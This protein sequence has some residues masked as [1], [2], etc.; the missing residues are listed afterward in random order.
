MG[1]IGFGYGSEWHLLRWLGYHRGQLTRHVTA[2]TGGEAVEWLDFGFS[3]A[4]APGKPDQELT[5][6]DFI[7]DAQVQARWRAFWPQS[8]SAQNWDAVGVIHYQD[9]KEWLLVEA[10]AHVG[11]LESEC[12]ARSAASLQKIK[13]ALGR[14]SRA[15]CT[16]PPPVENWLR[17]YYQYANRLAALYFLMKE[18][19]PSVPARLLTIYFCGEQRENLICP[20]SEAEWQPA[21]EQVKARLGLAVECELMQRVQAL[22]L[23]VNPGAVSRG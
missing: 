20:Q 13:T 14:A 17:P 5:G 1:K 10:K 16:K 21:L 19:A 6:L 12:K 18:C 23:P 22:F 7:P 3:A 4:N 11:E 8:G 2:V 9:H 15:F